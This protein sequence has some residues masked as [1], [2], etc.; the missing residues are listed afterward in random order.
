M[1]KILLV[2]GTRPE[3]I[4]ICPLIIEFK[5]N[6]HL[7]DIKVC[8]TGQ[9]K[10]ILHQVFEFYNIKLDFDLALMEKGQS[11]SSLTAKIIHNMDKIL[12]LEK[13][14]IV[15]V[16][17]DT[18]TSFST[19][20]A[21][22][23]NKIRVAHVEAG[24]RTQ[25]IFSPWPEEL[26][27]QLTGR[28][29][30]FHFCPTETNYNNLIDESIS[31]TNLFVVGNTVID[32]LFY[33]IDKIEN[34]LNLKKS[35]KNEFIKIGLSDELL[36]NEKI[37]LI[38]CHRRENFGYKFINICESIKNLA[39]K[40][41]DYSFIFPMHP[42][43]NIRDT[44]KTYFS[45]LN[46]KNLFFIEPLDY[47][48]FV[49]LM[50]ISRFILTDSGGIQEEAPSLGK[51]VLVLRSTTERIEAVKAGT[52]LLVG[53]DTEKIILESEKLLND[54]KYYNNFIGKSNPYGDG[55]TSKKIV[56]I[57]IKN[58]FNE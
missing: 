44:I 54:E 41:H 12:S 20:L 24:L 34:D 50:K 26:N 4:K 31:K 19:A 28:I 36:T 47:L 57:I 43:P 11:L 53:T 14:D 32:S 30:E 42:N 29:A 13:P 49:Y 1:K 5:K 23:Y 46:I 9:H 40:Y 25:D 18:T 17:G 15:F 56:D 51:P 6:Q 37:I 52:V 33:V 7:F 35:I 8:S 21:C 16:H 39:I 58:I 2:I 38:T 22:Y 27:R 3:A 55:L 10:E 45:D 48:P